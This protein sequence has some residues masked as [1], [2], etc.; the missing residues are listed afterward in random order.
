MEKLT[1]KEKAQ[2]LFSSYLYEFNE[3]TKNRDLAKKCALI[4]VD[5]IIKS[6]PELVSG[7]GMGNAMFKN[8]LIDFFKQ[9]KTELELGW[10]DEVKSCN[11]EI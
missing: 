1:P 8:P 10:K 4:A 7:L 5:E 11:I 3:E 2:Y 9:V 6:Q